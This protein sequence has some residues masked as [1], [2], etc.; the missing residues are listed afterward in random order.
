MRGR[1]RSRLMRVLIADDDPISR[2]LLERTLQ[3]WGYEV[4]T[5]RDGDEA[6][7]FFEQHDFPLVIS[8]W[9]MPGVDG[10]EL[11]RRIRSCPRPG[12]VFIILLAASSHRQE[13]VEGL[14][15]GAD[16]FVTKP[17]DRAELR[18]RLRSGERILG[19]EQA[20]IERNRVLLERNRQMEDDLRMACEVQQ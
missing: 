15:A 13:V 3:Q 5:A 4:T 14:A 1:K 19:L 7:R 18:V 6:W 16:D 12:Y 10:I 2:R 9:V 17:F 20:L 11:V 8:D